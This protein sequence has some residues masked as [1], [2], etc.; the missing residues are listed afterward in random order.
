[1]ASTALMDDR[2]MSHGRQP[3]SRPDGRSLLFLAPVAAG[4]EARKALDFGSL[5]RERDPE[6]LIASLDD[7]TEE[8]EAKATGLNR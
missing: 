1:M 5:F 6:T 4:A 3:S 8:K 2:A 7:E